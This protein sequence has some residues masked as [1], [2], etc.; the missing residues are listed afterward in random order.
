HFRRI[1]SGDQVR[2]AHQVE[3]PL[4]AQPAAATHDLVLHHRDVSRGTTET[5]EAKLEED[6]GYVGERRPP[7]GHRHS[8]HPLLSPPRCR[9]ASP[10]RSWPIS[11]LWQLPGQVSPVLLWLQASLGGYSTHGQALRIVASEKWPSPL[12]GATRAGVPDDR[13]LRGHC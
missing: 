9:L 3:E 12:P 10:G 5:Q 8:F 6:V 1:R 2:R 4:P 11:P 7:T 13:G